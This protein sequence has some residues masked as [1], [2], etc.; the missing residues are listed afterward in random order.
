[1]SG[2]ERVHGAA[3]GAKPG[4]ARDTRRD[5]R[6]QAGGAA[7]AAN[8]GARE[9]RLRARRARRRLRG[10]ERGATRRRRRDVRERRRRPRADVGDGSQPDHRPG[11]GRARRGA[12]AGAISAGRASSRP[13]PPPRRGGWDPRRGRRGG[14][15]RAR[16]GSRRG[17]GRSRV[18]RARADHGGALVS[19]PS[20][21][22]RPRDERRR[23]RDRRERS[24]GADGR[25]PRR[26][27]VPLEPRPAAPHPVPPRRG[28]GR[29]RVRSRRTPDRSALRPWVGAGL[30]GSVR[31]VAT[32]RFF[33]EVSGGVRAALVR[34]RFFFEP[35]SAVTVF[36]A[37]VVSGFAG[38]AVG[39]TILAIK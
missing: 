21:R 33:V 25:H 37:P 20:P 15:R 36:Q 26:L 23:C 3:R 7:H 31:Y 1:M 9:R 28:G 13:A 2:R 30:L 8:G 29:Q 12:A 11:R 4:R 22:C 38:A 24:A 17:A 14:R 39:F 16:H 18:R 6:A 19:Q 32:R 35:D 10:W 5:E 34:D 27:P